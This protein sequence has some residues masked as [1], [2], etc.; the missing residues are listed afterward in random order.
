[1]QARLI[2]HPMAQ[3]ARLAGLV[4][5]VR[6]VRIGA[7]EDWGVLVEGRGFFRLLEREHLDAPGL[8]RPSSWAAPRPVTFPSR[9]AA[10]N[11]AG[12]VGLI[13]AERSG[14]LADS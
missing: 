14:P 1:M 3:L 9:R 10:A 7:G 11:Y 13:P 8:L 5:H 12:T 4:K 2:S 6:P